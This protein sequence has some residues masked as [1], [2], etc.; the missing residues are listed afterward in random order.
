MAVN[1]Y[2]GE[3]SFASGDTSQTVSIGGTVDTSNAFIIAYGRA[4]STDLERAEYTGVFNSTTQ[5]TLE[6]GESG[7]ASVSTWQVVE[8]TNGEFEVIDSGI[9]SVGSTDTT[10]NETVTDVG[11]TSQCTVFYSVR[12][13]NGDNRTTMLYTAELT[14]TTNLQLVRQSSGNTSELQFWIVKWHAD[15]NVYNGSTTLTGSSTTGSIGA[16]VDLSRTVLFANWNADTNGLAQTSARFY[17]TTTDV[18]ITRATSTGS[19]DSTW[20]VVEFPADVVVQSDNGT[21]SPTLDT[22]T[23]VTVSAVTLANTMNVH[24]NMCT[25]TGTAY[26]RPLVTSHLSTTTNLQ[27]R[28]DYSGQTKTV[29]YYIADFS[30]WTLSSST[31][32]T[33]DE[34]TITPIA[35]SGSVTSTSVV[36][37]NE[38]VVQSFADSGAVVSTSVIASTEGAIQAFADNGSITGT[39][40]VVGTEGVI[41]SIADNG[42]VTATSTVVGTEGVITAIADNGAV[43]VPAGT[44]TI[45]A[46]EGVIVAVADSGI[47]TDP[48]AY[49]T[50][51]T[52]A[53]FYVDDL[54]NPHLQVLYNNGWFINQESQRVTPVTGN[55][56]NVD[57]DTRYLIELKARIDPKAI[58]IGVA[59]NGT[60]VSTSVI[61]GT[62]GVIEAFADEA[63]ITTSNPIVGAEGVIIGI[64]DNGTVVQTTEVTANEGVIVSIADS[65][66]IT[67]TSTISGAEGVITAHADNGTITSTST[68]VATE[69][70]IISISDNGVVESTATIIATEGV[71][72][73]IADNGE[74]V[75]PATN[76]V[77]AEGVIV[78]VADNGTVTSTSVI[79]GTEGII[80]PIADQ[81]NI[82]ADATIVGNEGVLIS[83]GDNGT[84]TQTS[85]I[86]GTDG[87]IIGIADSGTIT[88]TST[89][90]GN[91]G[92][93]TPIADN[94][95]VTVSGFKIRVTDV[96]NTRVDSSGNIRIT[97]E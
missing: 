71:I 25:G 70:A 50:G 45:T 53:G 33:A 90:V 16:T 20:S 54:G 92:I 75:P 41:I 74:I 58:L 61:A 6:R 62:E 66:A 39:S 48:S 35:D 96:G 82:V 49:I 67:S 27:L 40:T 43:T 78:A 73:A 69:G 55:I 12:H 87:V 72:I 77:G 88:G 91:E 2:R 1:V 10:V 89:V 46:D 18:T 29:T 60:V 24:T 28:Q 83:I 7:T 84:V 37:G 36:A 56:W 57:E 64:A 26:P 23:D 94:G 44:T 95:V 9:V 15:V 42:T 51:A 22:T 17:L 8:A 14:T 65:G 52:T 32:I 80:T 19:C 86:V 30:A 5:I 59:D 68:I 85:V 81:A 47:V 4:A 31:T 97:K 34:G 93:I 21:S 3:T 76:I 38:G 63:S 79:A 13:G 11:D